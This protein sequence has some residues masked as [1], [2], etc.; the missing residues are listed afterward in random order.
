[1]TA[2]A[3]GLVSGIISSTGRGALAAARALR[4]TR[5]WVPEVLP[6]MRRLGVDSV[7]IA[8]F[9]AV[10]TGIGM[11]SHDHEHSHEEHDHEGL[12]QHAAAH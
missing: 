12:H 8:V 4:D 9:L 10:F 2:P 1:M 5:T 3:G 11:A 6:L 7:P